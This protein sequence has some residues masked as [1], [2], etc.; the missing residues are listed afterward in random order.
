MGVD[1]ILRANHTR[2]R[3]NLVDTIQKHDVQH[4]QREDDIWPIEGVVKYVRKY[5]GYEQGVFDAEVVQST[6][7]DMLQII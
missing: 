1:M 6:N 7:V 2:R 3:V 5:V 4:H